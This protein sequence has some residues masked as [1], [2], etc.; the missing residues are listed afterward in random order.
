ML[1][2][3]EAFAK[4]QFFI[5]GPM[6]PFNDA[7]LPGASG[8]DSSVHQIEFQNKSFKGAFPLRVG[9]EFH[10][11]LKGVVG[12]D[13]EKGGS[14]SSARFSTPATVAERRSL[15][16]SEYLTRVRR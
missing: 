11:E 5:I 12:P 8:T 1:G 10:S 13:E 15:W 14:K 6:A 4:E 9:T 16:I 7:I 2:I 3:D